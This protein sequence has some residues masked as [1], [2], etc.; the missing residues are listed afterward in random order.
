M[1]SNHNTNVSFLKP[2]TIISSIVNINVYK[3][4]TITYKPLYKL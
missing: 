1:I 4:Y 3:L 2:I